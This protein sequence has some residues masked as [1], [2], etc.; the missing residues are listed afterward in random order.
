MDSQIASIARSEPWVFDV[1]ECLL[2]DRSAFSPSFDV[3]RKLRGEA[4]RTI[5]LCPADTGSE[6]RLPLVF[7]SHS[8][9][10]ATY[11]FHPPSKLLFSKGGSKTCTSHAHPILHPLHLTCRTSG[12]TT[13]QYGRR[14]LI[15]IPPLR[16]TLPSH[17]DLPPLHTNPLLLC[18]RPPLRYPSQ[19]PL[20]LR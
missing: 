9:L 1:E 7:A 4:M 12:R 6:N 5:C 13:T 15:S 3:T 11:S 14:L 19:Q 8:S 18:R 20:R 17:R 16:P 10:F 2:C